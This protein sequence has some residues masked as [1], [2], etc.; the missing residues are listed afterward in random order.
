MLSFLPEWVASKQ[1]IPVKLL[2]T[3]TGPPAS[4]PAGVHGSNYL[5]ST[6]LSVVPDHFILLFSLLFHHLSLQE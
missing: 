5:W 3:S 6:P 4:P 2:T 1:E